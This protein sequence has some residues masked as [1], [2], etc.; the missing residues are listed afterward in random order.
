MFAQR[1]AYLLT[2]NTLELGQHLH[3]ACNTPDCVNP[4][5]MVVG[6]KPK[7]KPHTQNRIRGEK[8]PWSKL[9]SETVVQIRQEYASGDTSYTQLAKK[10]AMSVS[11]L[12][13]IIKRRSWKAV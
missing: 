7:K 4:S 11:A 8:H 9:T 3:Q 10:Y 6:A 5:H 2:G 12:A 1:A 13:A